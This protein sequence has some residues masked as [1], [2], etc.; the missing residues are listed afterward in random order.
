MK[1]D[2]SQLGQAGFTLLESLIGT[3]LLAT[4]VYV[5]ASTFATA[6]KSSTS[7]RS[8]LST[9]ETL[10]ATLARITVDLRSASRVAEDSN[11]NGTLDDGEDSNGNGRLDADWN[12][13][14]SSIMFNRMMADGTYSPPVCYF[15]SGDELRRSVMLTSGRTIQVPIARSV[16]NF[17]VS[18]SGTNVTIAMTIT[19]PG[20]VAETQTVTVAPRN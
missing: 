8:G 14:A 9:T 3:V 7:T 18:E 15:L 12:L 2:A 5:L 17:S 13:Q 4:I 1:R 16:T 19:R 11:S 10:R 20:G 6:Q